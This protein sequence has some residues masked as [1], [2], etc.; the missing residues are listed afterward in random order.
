M[1]CFFSVMSWKKICDQAVIKLSTETS[2]VSDEKYLTFNDY[3]K[4][5]TIRILYRDPDG[6]VVKALNCEIIEIVFELQSHCYVDVCNDTLGK[7]L[8]PK[9]NI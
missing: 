3:F 4:F 5:R 8:T 6:T 1:G 2:T 9:L 7:S